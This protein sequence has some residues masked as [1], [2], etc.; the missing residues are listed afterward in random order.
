MIASVA[1]V[2]PAGDNGLSVTA[3]TAITI[4]TAT[5]IPIR[6]RTAI[7]N[8][9]TAT[10]GRTVPATPTPTQSA[11]TTPTTTTT[12]TATPTATATACALPTEGRRK[13][14]S[15]GPLYP[16]DCAHDRDTDRNSDSDSDLDHEYDA[17]RVVASNPGCD[18]DH[19]PQEPQESE[20]NRDHSHPSDPN[21]T[22]VG[23]TG[24]QREM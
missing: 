4:L 13:Y 24:L 16:F 8:A 23:F 2:V 19:D 3:R 12:P 6:I 17:M 18:P 7:V 5:L 11:P 10:A 1:W 21:T 15:L 9:T 22:R 14:V 20:R